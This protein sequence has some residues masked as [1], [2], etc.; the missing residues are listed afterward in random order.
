MAG[1]AQKNPLESGL[2]HITLESHAKQGRE[3]EGATSEV[4]CK[5]RAIAGF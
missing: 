1:S 4:M 5:R 2:N 3:S